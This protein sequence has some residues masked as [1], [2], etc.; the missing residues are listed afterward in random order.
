[1]PFAFHSPAY[2]TLIALLVAKRRE[3]GM[4]QV[5][6]GKRLGRPQTF[7]SK[8]EQCERRLDVVEFLVI[9]DILGL[10]IMYAIKEVK[11]TIHS[12]HI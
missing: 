6:L 1:M 9:A 12:T 5:E 2:K 7:V 10:D 4:S 8:V 3:K 11:R